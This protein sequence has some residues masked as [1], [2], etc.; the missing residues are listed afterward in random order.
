MQSIKIPIEISARHLHLSQCD[1]DILFGRGYKLRTYIELSQPGEFAAKESIT[2]RGPKSKYT[3]VRIIGPL[4]D[5]TQ[6]EISISDSY[7]LGIFTPPVLVSGDLKKSAG[8]I[9]II[10]PKGEINLKKG[11]IIAKRHLHISPVMAK[12][13]NLKHLDLISIKTTSVRSIIFNNV[14]VRSRPNKDKLSFQ[15]DTDEANAAGIKKGDWGEV[16]AKS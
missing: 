3:N 16:C 5:E 9:N 6:L 12:K 11:V 10:G 4:R 15:I 2:I 13:L 8:G 1:L 7:Y 14:V